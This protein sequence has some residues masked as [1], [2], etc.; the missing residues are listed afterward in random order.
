MEINSDE[1]LCLS[2]DDNYFLNR[3]N[4]NNNIEEINNIYIPGLIKPENIIEKGE[5]IIIDD[6]FNKPDYII[7]QLEPLYIEPLPKI[8]EL[9]KS[10]H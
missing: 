6:S 4:E 1:G 8:S 9:Y 10:K 3:F 2:G 5:S 7:E